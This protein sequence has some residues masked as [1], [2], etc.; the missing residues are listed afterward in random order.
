V[1]LRFSWHL[2]SASPWADAGFEVAFDEVV[3][4]APT[5]PRR[6]AGASGHAAAQVGRTDATIVLAGGDSLVEVDVRTGELRGW[7]HRGVEVLVSPLRPVYWR[8]P[9]DNERGLANAVPLLERANPDRL[10]R[11]PGL[12][13]AGVAEDVDDEGAVV[14]V[15]L[16]SPLLRATTLQYRVRPDGSLEVDHR[17]EPRRSMVRVGLSTQVRGTDR[18]RW[19]GKGPH[20]CY[21][22]RQRGAWTAVHEMPLE[23]FGHDYVR[24]QENG[25]RTGVRW[26]ELWGAGS[27]L[28]VDDLTGDHLDV[29]A[30]PYTLHDLDTAQHIHELPRRDEVTLIVGRQRGVGGDLPGAAALLPAYRLP[31]GRP[32]RVHVRLTPLAEHR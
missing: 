24:P 8:A 5:A 11:H 6:P 27:G 23:Q 10:W 7:Q 25:N 13:V 9:T 26:V 3:L 1:V 30:W 28:R 20:E 29:T 15:T 12:G 19:Y 16:V 17:L 32:Y 21:V 18:V 22:D 31:G 14:T 2:T 4:P